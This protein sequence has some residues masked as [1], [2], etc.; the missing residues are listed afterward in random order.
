MFERK[1][2]VF[3]FCLSTSTNQ[4]TT[5][6]VLRSQVGSD[7]GVRSLPFLGQKSYKPLTVSEF[8]HSGSFIRLRENSRASGFQTLEKKKISS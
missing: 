3:F 1:S 5:N 4:S 7:D 2:V 6:L 8:G